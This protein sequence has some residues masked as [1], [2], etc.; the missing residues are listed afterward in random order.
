M[1]ISCVIYRFNCFCEKSYI[2]QTSRHLKTRL[3]EHVPKCVEIFIEGK[4]NIKSLALINATKRSSIAEHLVN[5]LDCGKNNKDTRFKI[6]QQCP[7]VYDLFK[8]E[9]IFI[10][11][12]KP[13]LC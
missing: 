6:V 9:A 4:V 2:G 7:N 1:D 10:Y 5:N 8:L 11:L 12:N 3:K 13:E